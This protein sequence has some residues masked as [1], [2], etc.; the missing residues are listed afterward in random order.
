MKIVR[1][2]LIVVEQIVGFDA[3]GKAIAEK[4]G[5]KII[6]HYLS[7]GQWIDQEIDGE[8]NP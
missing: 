3:E 5:Q 6:R 2:E 8:I 7:T 4:T 1:S